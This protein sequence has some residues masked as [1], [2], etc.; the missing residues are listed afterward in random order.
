[1]KRGIIGN[2][3]HPDEKLVSDV[4]DWIVWDNK[5]RNVAGVSKTYFVILEVMWHW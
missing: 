3:H 5:T 2:T 4:I 1:M